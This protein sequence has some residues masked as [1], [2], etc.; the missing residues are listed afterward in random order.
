[1]TPFTESLS[2]SS[3]EEEDPSAAGLEFTFYFTLGN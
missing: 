1:M 3:E 2:S